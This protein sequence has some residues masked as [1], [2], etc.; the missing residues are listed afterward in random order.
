MLSLFIL[1]TAVVPALVLVGFIYFKDKFRREP[2]GQLVKGFGFG[3]LSALASF[4]VSMPLLWLGF[5]PAEASTFGGHVAT[6]FFG[7]AI[8]EELAKL[9]MLWLLLRKNKHFDE[10]A[11]GM[12]YAVCIG[13]GFAALENIGYLFNNAEEWV[14]VGLLRALIPI[15]GHFFFAVTMGYFYSLA[16]FGDPAKRKFNM[17]MAFLVPMLLHGAFDA[18]LMVSSLGGGVAAVLLFFVALYLYM[19]LKSKKRFEAHMAID[20]KT[21]KVDEAIKAEL[22]DAADGKRDNPVGDVVYLPESMD[23]K[24]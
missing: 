11:D 7:A 8:P 3:A 5:Y 20:D 10:Y 24:A 1:I 19:A 22:E 12:V 18:L 14:S 23:K 17:W 13:M 15:P 9:F 21:R 4:L 2:T 16:S 6:A